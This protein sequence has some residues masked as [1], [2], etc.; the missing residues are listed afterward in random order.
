MAKAF[1]SLTAR[2]F[3]KVSTET[4]KSLSEPDRTILWRGPM[5]KVPKS[6]LAGVPNRSDLCI[7]FGRATEDKY[8]HLIKAQRVSL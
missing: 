2:G 8:F 5:R 7:V 4:T 1:K 6:Q 3:G